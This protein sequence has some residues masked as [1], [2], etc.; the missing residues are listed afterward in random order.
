M[1]RGFGH[2][3]GTGCIL[4]VSLLGACV[5]GSRRSGNGP[6]DPENSWTLGLLEHSPLAG[7]TEVP[8]TTSVSV[9][10]DGPI[11]KAALDEQEFMLHEGD[12]VPL[13]GSFTAESDGRRIVFTPSRPLEKASWYEFTLSPTLCDTSFRT[14]DDEI[15]F[16]FRTFD[17][18]PP[19][20]LGSSVAQ[21]ARDVS[22][23]GRITLRLDEDVDPSSVHAGSVTLLDE[24][25]K[26]YELEL[27]QDAGTL[28]LGAWQDLPGSRGY[29][30]TLAAGPSGIRDRSGNALR[31][32]WA[33][34]FRTERDTVPPRHVSPD[35]DKIEEL[36]A[37]LARIRLD[38][39]ES[40]DPESYE[41]AGVLVED[42]Q[43]R[44]VDVSVASSRDLKTLYLKPLHPLIAG[45]RYSVT[46]EDEDSGLTDVSGNHLAEKVIRILRVS[47][48]STPPRILATLPRAS[49]DRVSPNVTPEISFDEALDP[50]S[51]QSST[52]RL[53]SGQRSI[54][55]S[56]SLNSR[57]SGIRVSPEA[58]LDVDTA[59][60]LTIDGGYDGVLDRVGN[61][62]PA[63]LRL[64][65]RSSSSR[66]LP[67]FLISP[68]NGS[69]AVPIDCRI[70]A[71]AGGPLDPASVGPDSL[72][73]TTA[74]EQRIAGVLSLARG[75]RALVFQ[76]HARLP[77]GSFLRARVKSGAEGPRLENGNWL[78]QDAESSFRVGFHTDSS[79]PELEI[80]LNDILQ[81]R[82]KGLLVPT[83]G[84][85]LN[86]QARDPFD[87]TIDPTT[88]SLSLSGPG[89]LPSAAELFGIAALGATTGNILLPSTRALSPGD[90]SLTATIMDLAGRKSAPASLSFSVAQTT[91]DL[92]PF[93]RTQF[94]WVRFDSDREAGTGDGQADLVQ[95]LY[96]LG[97]MARN[98][99]G[100]TN[101]YML[102]VL[103]DG[104]L[105]QAN[106]LMDR[107][108]DGSRRPSSVRL[109]FVTRKP[110]HP[111][112]MQIAVGGRD[113]QG[114]HR[115]N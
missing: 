110:C 23:S 70:T 79:D 67:R 65:F 35:P 46:L 52:V 20:V 19:R 106:K 82:N 93:E 43:R 15:S 17:D 111:G 94:V 12:R 96:D 112:F 48:D 37:P 102:R 86:S 60:A 39:S 87:R 1:G 85:S 109:R 13:P 11:S 16:R 14:L 71:L 64:E 77:Q 5:K 95:D 38:F 63:P 4:V 3:T 83:F 97:L 18:I 51:V 75:N 6:A 103:T 91:P 101:E 8:V 55:V 41:A 44:S 57:R 92:L 25:R 54:P 7:A 76:P 108:P 47:N 81:S 56:V 2:R 107:N 21:N 78:G 90:Y 80:T 104:V 22:R 29:V 50:R 31:R 49:A 33:L 26:R 34:A 40:M 36:I 100:G 73:V 114:P 69:S 89:P 42:S 61:P 59:Y 84:F 30:L 68:S 99:P 9:T 10:F 88:L 53:Q 98:D 115:R 45:E 24:S 74:S 32:D 62:L 66:T 28:V 105:R 58:L 113:P 72:V 27:R